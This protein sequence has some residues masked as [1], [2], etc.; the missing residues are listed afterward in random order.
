[1]D[2]PRPLWTDSLGRLSI[3]SGQTLLVLA[4]VSLVVLAT[5]QL[6]IIVIPVFIA[7]ILASA[8]YPLVRWL[9]KHRFPRP[10]ATL[11]TLL[12][13]V[14]VLGGIITLVVTGVRSQW[15]DL[16]DAVTRAIDT[17]QDY[18]QSGAFPI[19]TSQLEEVRKSIGDFLTSAQFGSTA[20]A[21]AGTVVELLTGAVLT[22]VLLFFFLQDGPEMW[23]FLLRPL[24]PNRKRRA[25]RVGSRATGVLGGY[26]RGTAIVALV[27]TIF[28]GLALWI[29]QVPLALP[30][31]LLVFVGAFIPIVGATV[32]G[33]LAAL[34]ALVTND[35]VTALIVAGVVILVNQL[36]GNLL[37]P[38]VLGNALKLHALVILLALSAGTILGGIIG[39][40]LAVPL[41][42][43][44]WAAIKAWNEPDAT[45][46]EPATSARL[47][48]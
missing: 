19:D 21:G 9:V 38:V 33:T 35:L 44:A 26:I 2:S 24:R 45:R 48:S 39:T 28:I 15:E 40:F 30:L 7:L 22:V 42:A 8:L 47:R 5:I 13:G 20:L 4:L 11:G 36:E 29:L 12:A 10:L 6:K 43:V 32:A 16:S 34:V 17:I 41:A 25:R 27:D 3:R 46:L 23:E 14:V 31:A 18:L 1:M 37:A